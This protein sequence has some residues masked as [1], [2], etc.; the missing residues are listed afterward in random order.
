MHPYIWKITNIQIGDYIHITEKFLS[1]IF[2]SDILVPINQS[3]YKV[4]MV[5]ISI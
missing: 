4:E 3:E 2:G 1:N 5:F